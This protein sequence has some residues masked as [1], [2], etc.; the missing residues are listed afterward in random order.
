MLALAHMWPTSATAF[1]ARNRFRISQRRNDALSTCMT[2][3]GLKLKAPMRTGKVLLAP[4]FDVQQRN[5]MTGRKGLRLITTIPNDL[6]DIATSHD[7]TPNVA[8]EGNRLIS[9][10]SSLV[11][12]VNLASLIGFLGIHLAGHSSRSS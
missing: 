3:R 2:R 4:R 11:K 1:H 9:R 6:R 5:N 12:Y 7:L 10:K 8:E